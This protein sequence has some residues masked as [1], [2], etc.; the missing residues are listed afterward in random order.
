M[1]ERNDC[2]IVDAL[3][4]MPKVMGKV[5]Q[6]QQNPQ[7]EGVESCG[8]SR[9]HKNNPPTFKGRYDPKVLRFSCNRSRKSLE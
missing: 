3:E 9:F 5:L 2:A 6:A 1:V 4:T 7:A 8:L